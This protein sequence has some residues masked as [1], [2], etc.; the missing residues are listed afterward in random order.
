MACEDASRPTRPADNTAVIVNRRGYAVWASYRT[1]QR[2]EVDP[3]LVAVQSGMRMK[4]P[5]HIPDAS[6]LARGIDSAGTTTIESR[7]RTKVR[8]IAIAVQE[9]TTFRVN[10]G[11]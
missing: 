2:T 1:N 3:C 11:Y 5:V 7:D 8:E 9:G 6:D 10:A 4:P